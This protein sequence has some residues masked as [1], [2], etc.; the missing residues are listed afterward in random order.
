MRKFAQG[1]FGGSCLVLGILT[2]HLWLAIL[3]GASIG[4]TTIESTK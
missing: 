3:G 2:G 1:L 4:L